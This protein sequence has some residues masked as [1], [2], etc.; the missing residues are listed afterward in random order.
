MKTK[1][2]KHTLALAI[3]GLASQASQAAC[4]TVGTTGIVGFNLAV[5]SNFYLSAQ[6]IATSFLTQPN[7]PPKDYD[8]YIC[9]GSSGNLYD[10][11]TENEN[12]APQYALFLS[13][14]EERPDAIWTGQYSAALAVAA[15]FPYAK[16]T[17]VFLLSPDAYQGSA[18]AYPALDFLN[19]GLASG[20]TAQSS[21]SG[22]TISDYV[23]IDTTLVATLAIGEP[24]LAPYGVQAAAI[25]GRTDDP[26]HPAPANNM[27]QWDTPASAGTDTATA[28]S[29]IIS[30]SPTPETWIC[31]YN[32]INLTLDAI[33]NDQVTAGFVSYG[34]VCSTLTGG[35]YPDDQFVLFEDYPTTQDG[36]LL[37]VTDTTAQDKAADFKAYMLGGAGDD[38][39]DE[40]LEDNCYQGLGS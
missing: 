37:K 7:E 21:V 9:E 33:N 4:T 18:A 31:A 19:T 27:G 40:W 15:P 8:I 6:T 13:A 1:F 17:P 5:A 16:G 30:G 23:D 24:S 28:C 29:T 11:I 35:A 39:W 12:N 25:L 2:L 22:T 14:D 10:A 34:Q 38:S 20:A 32:N 3:L 26:A 36:I